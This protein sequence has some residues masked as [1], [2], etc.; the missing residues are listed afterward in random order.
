MKLALLSCSLVATGLLANPSLHAQTNVRFD[1]NAGSFDV[2]LNPTNNSD[3]Q[4]LVDNFLQYVTSGRYDGTVINRA[5]QGFVVQLGTFVADVADTGSIPAAGFSQ[6]AAFAPVI[7]D[8]D[9]DRIVDLNTTGL[10][11]TRGE[12]ALALSANNP[13]SGTSSFFANLD[14]NSFL[15][16][17][18]FVPFARI[19]DL[20]VFDNLSNGP[21]E[22]LSQQIGQP[23]NFAYT[24]VPVIDGDK[25]VVI[26]RAYVTPE[27]SSALLATIALFGL[28]GRRRG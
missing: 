8:T 2:L 12:V 19:E 21:R 26:E 9:G 1:T 3:L 24:D 18:G 25:L 10:S 22:D 17:Q 20:T 4:G 15:D 6:I 28:A 13:N 7:T 27:P 23:R 5:A 14:D 16:D 11:N